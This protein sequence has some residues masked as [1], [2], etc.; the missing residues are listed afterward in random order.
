MTVLNLG[1]PLFYLVGFLTLTIYFAGFP[2]TSSHAK[3]RLH[4]LVR[5]SVAWSVTR[6]LWGIIAL[7]SV[8]QGW[9]AMAEENEHYYGLTL[10]LLFVVTEIGPILW[11]LDETVITYLAE[12]SAL[13]GMGPG[14]DGR[15]SSTL[16]HSL[17]HS[18]DWAEE[19]QST[20]LYPYPT[21]PYILSDSPYSTLPYPYLIFLYIT[22]SNLPLLSPSHWYP[23][24]TPTGQAFRSDPGY[25][26]N[27]QH[28]PVYDSFGRRRGT[29]K[30]T[31]P[32]HYGSLNT[33]HLPLDAVESTV[34]GGV[35]IGSGSEERSSRRDMR[36]NARRAKREEEADEE[37][38]EK[39]EE[40]DEITT[41]TT[42]MR[43][44]KKR[45]D[46]ETAPLF[47]TGGDPLYISTPL[48]LYLHL[49]LPLFLHVYPHF[50]ITVTYA[51]SYNN[52]PSQFQ[53]QCHDC[54]GYGSSC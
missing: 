1:I 11:G 9:L 21:L 27:N 25:Y 37:E 7:T 54:R 12:T 46:V 52:P 22:L 44:E 35:G 13:T 31:I 34:V 19:G 18:L 10:V 53:H 45:R 2:F 40:D 43:R 38:G 17:K 24:C 29:G 3:L 5:L 36:R 48:H 39:K 14:G 30:T 4:S 23:P 41:T 8:V 26:G 28:D 20:V 51:Y 49:Y 33:D 32:S 47:A 15:D 6:L 16:H 50:V 42:T